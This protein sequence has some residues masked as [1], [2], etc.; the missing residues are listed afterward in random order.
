M[1]IKLWL[2]QHFFEEKKNSIQICGLWQLYNQFYKGLLY[3]QLSR[4]KGIV[5]PNKHL[6]L[7]PFFIIAT[8]LTFIESQFAFPGVS[9][10]GNLTYSIKNSI[11]QIQIQFVWNSNIQSRILNNLIKTSEKL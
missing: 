2:L 1:Q 6:R 10:P 3:I 9:K 5:T 4:V 11:S 8:Y 7:T